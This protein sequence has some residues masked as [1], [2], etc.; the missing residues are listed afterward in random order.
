MR[1]SRYRGMQKTH[2][3][4]LMCATCINLVRALAWL[5]GQPL[6]QTRT[7]RFAALALGA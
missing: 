2:F 3:Q 6:A 4:H 7:S 1:R 5:E